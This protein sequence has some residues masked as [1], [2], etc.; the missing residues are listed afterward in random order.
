MR[1]KAEDVLKDMGASIRRRRQALGREMTQERLAEKAGLS[2]SYISMIE[3][4]E[5]MPTLETLA[6]LAPVL[7]STLPGLFGSPATDEDMLTQGLVALVHARGLSAADVARLE[8]VT[9]LMFPSGSE[10]AAP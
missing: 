4:G 8:Q 5:R 10:E 7:G 1:A 2:V 6:A 9:R 3:R